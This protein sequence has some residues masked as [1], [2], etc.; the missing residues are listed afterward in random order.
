METHICVLQS[1]LEL[2]AAGYEELTQLVKA[3]LRPK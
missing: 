1:A 2:K 3:K